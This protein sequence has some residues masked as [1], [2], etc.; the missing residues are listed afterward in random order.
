MLDLGTT[1]M[2]Y[3][4]SDDKSGGNDKPKASHCDKL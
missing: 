2:A 4:S 3:T 1:T